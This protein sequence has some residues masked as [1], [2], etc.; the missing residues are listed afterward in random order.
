MAAATGGGGGVAVPPVGPGTCLSVETV[1]TKTITAGLPTTNPNNSIGDACFFYN[2]IPSLGFSNR[3]IEELFHH[4]LS[5]LETLVQL[6]VSYLEKIAKNIRSNKSPNA[7]SNVQLFL[8]S[9]GIGQFWMSI[10][11]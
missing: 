3:T 6:T 1:N 11:R 2:V 9:I 7:T 10:F 8:R 4:G 5:S